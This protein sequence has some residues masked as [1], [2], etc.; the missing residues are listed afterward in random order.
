MGLADFGQSEVTVKKSMLLERMRENRSAH[1]GQFLKAL[2]GYRVSAIGEL[3]R[4][5]T[6]AKTGRD[7]RRNMTLLE[8]KDHTADYDRVIKMLEWST[9]DEVSITERQFAQYVDDNWEWSQQ[10][11]AITDT[12]NAPRRG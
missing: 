8:P 5:V 9:A 7:I 6:D 3:E 1:R 12:Y 10:F 11:K 2:D 4:M